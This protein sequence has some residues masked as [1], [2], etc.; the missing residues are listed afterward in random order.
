[1]NT[2]REMKVLDIELEN[3]PTDAKVSKMAELRIRNFL[4]FSELQSYNDTGQWRYKHPFVIH[5]SERARL[6][7]LK[8]RDPEAFLRKYAN[9]SYNIKRYISFLKNDTRADRRE[10]DKKNLT[11]YRELETIFKDIISNETNNNRS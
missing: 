2:Y 3:K 9:C 1:M 7:E 10:S 11:R 6:E 5:Q 4:C 8:R